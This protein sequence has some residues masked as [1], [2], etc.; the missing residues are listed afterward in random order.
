MKIFTVFAP[1][2]SRA[3]QVGKV[4]VKDPPEATRSLE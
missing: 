4:Q 2:M 1:G 3:E